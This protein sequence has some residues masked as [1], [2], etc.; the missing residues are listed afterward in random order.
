MEKFLTL[1]QSDYERYLKENSSVVTEEERNAP[2]AF[3]YGKMGN[4]FLRSQ[5]DCYHSH[6]PHRTFDLKT[7]AIMPIRLDIPHYQVIEHFCVEME[8]APNSFLFA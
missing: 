1:E 2:E 8:W 3:A 7:R 4:L 6:L 5:L